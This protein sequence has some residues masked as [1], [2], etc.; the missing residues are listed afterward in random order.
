MASLFHPGTRSETF[1]NK[2]KHL[3]T[4]EVVQT[5]HMHMHR[6]YDVIQSARES[7]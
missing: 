4:Q 7:S 5:E 2:G 6:N 1:R 3:I